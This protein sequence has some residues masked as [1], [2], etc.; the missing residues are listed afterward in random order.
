MSA[1][2]KK[3]TTY[4]IQPFREIAMKM[5]SGDKLETFW[6]CCMMPNPITTNRDPDVLKIKE[7]WKLTP[8]EMYDHPRMQELRHNLSNNI[9]DP[10][11]ETCWHQEDRGLKSFRQWSNEAELYEK[12]DGLSIV[13]LT[14]SNV[15]NLRCRMCSPTSS[16]ELMIDHR[17]FEKNGLLPEVHKITKRW[18]II[19][20]AVR[21]VES[22]Q[23]KW[24][25]E[26]TDKI[27]YVKASGGEPFYDKK[28]IKLMERYIETGNA[29]NTI[30]HFHTNATLFDDKIIK[31]LNEFKKNDHVFSI[32]GMG[33]TYEYI[34]Y[35]A[36]FEQLETSINLYFKEVKNYNR[37][38]PFAKII[39]AHNLLDTD[40]YIRWVRE[41]PTEVG[42]Q[43]GE[44]YDMDRGIA[45]KHLPVKLLKTARQR[46]EKYIYRD[47]SE[48]HSVINLLKMVDNAILYNK[49]NKSL[50]KA[51]TEL[52]DKSR[53]QSYR[54]YLDP[55][56]V[57]WLDS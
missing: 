18:G 57:E 50:I 31:I 21:A 12:E 29:K 54:D 47:G 32:D 43:Y 49:E 44:I 27:K 20:Q 55:D 34:R 22:P 40:K 7:V 16:N 46:I 38:V 30:L 4:C 14:F 28:M 25:L 36:T 2:S 17:Y 15:C 13:D 8:Q 48:E 39:S 41:L 10:A 35:P 5:F 6:P 52:F 37:I 26:N 33:K 45:I 42:V 11:C 23:W 9:R 24:L 19:E 53:N 3:S 1:E 51:E 56:L